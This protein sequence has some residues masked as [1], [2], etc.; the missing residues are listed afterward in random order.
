MHLG[1]L[2]TAL[3]YVFPLPLIKRKDR[4][5]ETVEGRDAEED[6]GHFRTCHQQTSGLSVMTDS[7]PDNRSLTLRVTT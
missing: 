5:V 2:C 7:W 1:Y 6:S 4:L 3:E